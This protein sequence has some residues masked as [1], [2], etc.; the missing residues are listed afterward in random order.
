MENNKLEL[1]IET[2]ALAHALTFANSVVEKRNIIPELSNIKLMAKDNSIVIT[3]TDMDL[4]L[5]QNI[6][7]QVMKEGAITVS[8]QTLTD[9]VKRIPDQEIKLRVAND[10]DQLEVIAK[11]CHFNLLTLPSS[12]FPVMEEIEAESVLKVSCH[13]F[14]RII[15]YTQFSMSLEET[16]Y[17]LNGIYLHVKEGELCAVSTDGHRLSLS[18]VAIDNAK[19]FGVIL[20]RKTIEEIIKIVKDPK[21][22]QLDLEVCL[23]VNKIKFACNNIVMISKLIDGTFPEYSAFIPL[24][25]KSK[26]TINSKV[27][28]D[29]AER[30]ATI[31]VDKFRAIKML[32]TPSVIEV[33]ASG[34]ARGSGREE[35]ICS[36]EEGNLCEFD[37][38]N[39]TI[40]FNPKYLID[41][42]NAIKHNQIE[43]HFHDSVSPVLIK[44]KDNYKS[45]FVIMPVKV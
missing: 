34:E 31:T 41:V 36:K 7:A 42:L 25:N 14:A 27:L 23:S 4:Y 32:L 8:T 28:A 3:A 38:G 6:G 18:S 11:N 15:D 30:V 40:G 10:S 37:G 16:R 9:I 29:V 5:N 19:E 17:N 1:I 43:L 39:I 44:I 22:I 20:P 2:K 45:T 33:T 13:N 24:E 35:I 21:N 12:H 26:L